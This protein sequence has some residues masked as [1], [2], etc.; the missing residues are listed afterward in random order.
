MSFYF[1]KCF[2]P[3][4]RYSSPEVKQRRELFMFQLEAI[5]NTMHKLNSISVWVQK[6]FNGLILKVLYLKFVVQNVPFE[7]ADL[8]EG[9]TILIIIWKVLDRQIYLVQVN[10]KLFAFINI[11]W[12]CRFSTWMNTYLFLLLNK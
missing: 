4:R 1:G 7:H 12:S 6:W 2:A 9:L 5:L 10:N 3:P 8:F 11:K